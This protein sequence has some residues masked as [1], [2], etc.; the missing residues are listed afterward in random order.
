MGDVADLIVAAIERPLLGL[1]VASWTGAVA[2]GAYWLKRVDDRR[3]ISRPTK[4][5]ASVLLV[6]ALTFT[7]LRFLPLTSHWGGIPEKSDALARGVWG[8]SNLGIS[9]VDWSCTSVSTLVKKYNI[10]SQAVDIAKNSATSPDAAAFMGAFYQ[11]GLEG[12]PIDL[13][14]SRKFYEFAAN[15]GS[16][17]GKIGLA[18]I[19]KERSLTDDALYW[20]RAASDNGSGRAAYLI[21]FMY[22]TGEGGL[23][24]NADLAEKW[25]RIAINRNCTEAAL[26]LS[27]LYSAGHLQAEK[28]S[29]KKYPFEKDI[30]ISKSLAM[31]AYAAG[32]MEAVYQIG[33]IAHK[34]KRYTDAIS[35]YQKDLG[36]EG[37][38]LEYRIGLIYFFDLNKN[39]TAIEWFR[40]A[41]ALKN[42][43]AIKYLSTI[44]SE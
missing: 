37:G 43:N 25:Y 10:S 8:A 20:L 33:W 32:D 19:S 17:R 31:D 7:T 38:E 41:A 3:L 16:L 30:N 27:G 29:G 34:E 35:W 44:D 26:E 36:V 4:I 15:K 14:V 21:G 28:K 2:L 42:E 6:L 24:P 1:T 12:K 9:D 23:E 5:A 39:E 11:Y 13:A 40:R 22:D 18:M